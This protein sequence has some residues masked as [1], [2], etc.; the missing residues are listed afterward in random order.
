MKPNQCKIHLDDIQT[1]KI[2]KK[3]LQPIVKEGK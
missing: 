3:T 1:I 2:D